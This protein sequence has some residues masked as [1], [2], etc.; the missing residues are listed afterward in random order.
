MHQPRHIHQ[1]IQILLLL[2]KLQ[3]G[4][5]LEHW[6]W[7]PACAEW[8]KPRTCMRVL[9]HTDRATHLLSIVPAHTVVSL[10]CIPPHPNVHNASKRHFRAMCAYFKIDGIKCVSNF[11]AFE[12]LCV[13]Q[14]PNKFE[15]NG[16]QS[17]GCH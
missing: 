8:S 13:L 14:G 6:V 1:S 17:L 15:Q 5:Q 4:S 3:L 9:T 2:N 7:W 12:N 10:T 11:N 16:L